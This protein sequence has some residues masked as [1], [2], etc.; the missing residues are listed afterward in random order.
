MSRTRALRRNRRATSVQPVAALAV[1]TCEVQN[2]NVFDGTD[3]D[4]VFRGV[5]IVYDVPTI[6]A[7]WQCVVTQ[8]GTTFQTVAITSVD[9]VTTGGTE[10]RV[11]CHIAQGVAFPAPFWVLIP[12]PVSGVS[13]LNGERVAGLYSAETGWAATAVGYLGLV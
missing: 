13:G 10:T 12:V 6:L 7:T 11:R 4:L 5:G 2:V 9:S 1:L 3:F 8:D